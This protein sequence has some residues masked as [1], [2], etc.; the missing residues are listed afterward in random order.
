M[1]TPELP[2]FE[3]RKGTTFGP[4][5][6]TILDSSGSAVNIAGCTVTAKAVAAEGDPIP[7][8]AY[9]AAV[10]NGAAGQFTISTTSVVTGAIRQ[11]VLLCNALL[12]WPSGAITE[13]A[14]WEHRFLERRT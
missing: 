10:S 9:T 2:A 4:E 14:I 3:T 8:F 13:E 7:V 5:T 6:I 12:T 1:A 11:S